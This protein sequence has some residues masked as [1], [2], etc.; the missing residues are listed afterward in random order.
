MWVLC[1][2]LLRGR[3][4][5]LEK[6]APMKSVSRRPAGPLCAAA[7]VLQGIGTTAEAEG[8]WSGQIAAT[9]DYVLRGVSQTDGHIAVQGSLAYRALSGVYAGAWASSLDRTDWYYPAG[10]AGLE[11][12]LFAGYGRRLADN[13]SVDARA[14]GYLYPEDGDF[15]DYA[16]VEFESALLYRDVVRMSVA[17]SPDVSLV[18]RQGLVEDRQSLA[19]DIAARAP[20]LPWLSFVAGIGFRDIDGASPGGYAYWNAGLSTQRGSLSIDLGL[21]GTDGNG[22]ELF[23]SDSAGSRT[24]VSVAWAF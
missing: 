16:Y 14:T 17:W 6:R 3:G 8:R 5:S 18:T 12:D 22:R 15:A 19:L 9:S 21:Y 24:A 13:W 20:L 4:Y 1:L 10:T 2:N 23:G 11:I 7:L